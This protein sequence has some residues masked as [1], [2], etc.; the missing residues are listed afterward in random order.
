MSRYISWIAVGVA[1]AFLVVASAAFSASATAWLAFAIAIGTLVVSA[2]IAYYSRSSAVS[3]YTAA[4][5]VLVSVWTIVASRVFSP[6]TVQN[7]ALA[8]SLAISGLALVG[9]TTHELEQEQ[10]L[11]SVEDGATRMGSRSGREAKLASA[12]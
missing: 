1:A 12:A 5:V 4:L 3:L 11:H 7:L 9:L 6:S 10:A 8:S 2:G